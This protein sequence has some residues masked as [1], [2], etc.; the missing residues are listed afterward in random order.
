MLQ[1]LGIRPA[2]VKT[3][4]FPCHFGTTKQIAEKLVLWAG[5]G[6]RTPSGAKAHVDISGPMYGLNPVPFTVSTFSASC[7]VVT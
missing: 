5:N 4:D 2:G 6:G 7:K 1:C 3:T